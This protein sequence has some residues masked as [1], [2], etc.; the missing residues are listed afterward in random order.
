MPKR[1]RDLASRMRQTNS[2]SKL[3]VTA[4]VVGCNVKRVARKEL[5]TGPRLLVHAAIH[6]F[7]NATK[8]LVILEY[9]LE[10][11]RNR[12]S[13]CMYDRRDKQRF[14][15]SDMRKAN[16]RAQA[17]ALKTGVLARLAGGRCFWPSYVNFTF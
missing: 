3:T 1:T 2:E 13:S 11:D 4:P 14:I 17:T 9:S 6:M 10:Q 5:M 16:M 12:L 7:S 15:G 8:V